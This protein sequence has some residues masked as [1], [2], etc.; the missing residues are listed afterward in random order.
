MAGAWSD[1][2]LAEGGRSEYVI[3]LPGEASPSE[4]HAANELQSF[5]QQICGAKLPIVNDDEPPAAAE[6][7]LAP[8]PKRLWRAG[9][10]NKRLGQLGVRVDWE[11]L[12]D[13]GFTIRTIGNHL[14]IAGGRLRGTLYGVYT[15]LEEHVGCRWFAEDCSQVPKRETI[16]LDHIDDTQIPLLEYRDTDYPCS[17][18]ADFA[19][20]N[21]LNGTHPRL[22]EARGGKISYSHF[23]HTFNSL[24][25]PDEYFEAHPE[26]FSLINGR[27]TKERT[28]LC[29]TNPDVLRIATQTVK[30][31]IKAAPDARIF[32]VSQNDWRNWCQCDR[33]TAVAEREGSQSGP[34]LQFV[35]AIAEQIEKEHP[36]VAISTLAYQYTRQPPKHVKPRD[37]VIVRL[38]SIEC[39]F[40]HPLA[41][42]ERNASFADDIRRW[43]RICDRLYIW[44]YVIDYSH[45]IMPFPNL[46]V[47]QPNIK[48]F[49][50][51]GVKGI[52][53]ESN[54]FSRGGEFSK[55]RTYL[56]AKALWNPDCDL[57]KHMDE[58]LEGYYG[59]A[60]RPI[61]QYIDM[62]HDKVQE[63]NIHCTI[64]T[65]PTSPLFSP[66]IVAR[67][68]RLFD[69]AEK[70]VADDATLLHRVQVALLPI[71]YVEISQG[72]P[73]YRLRGD[74]FVSEMGPERQALIDTF[75]RVAKAAKVT[76]IREGS[77]GLIEDWL[78]RLPQPRRGHP[79]LELVSPTLRVQIIPSLG[80]RIYSILDRRLYTNVLHVADRN[81]PLYPG[82]GGY[83]EYSES[84]Y[85]SPGWSEEYRVEETTSGS[86]VLVARLKNGLEL[87]RSIVL[88]ADEPKL[89]ITSTLTNRAKDP[90]TACLRVHPEFS[91]GRVDDAVL[92]MRRESGTW[93]SL[94]LAGALSDDPPQGK[95]LY[96]RG[97]EMPAGEW[98][99]VDTAKKLGVISAFEPR[100]VELCLLNF[101]GAEHRVNLELWSPERQ[102]AP[103]ESIIVT[104]TYRVVENT[105]P[106]LGDLR[107]APAG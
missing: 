97:D 98:M 30:E 65:P 50:E 63:E 51:N 34:L 73:K 22:D 11:K 40:A 26:Y 70:T 60:A 46:R 14:V 28:Q 47:L 64:R 18:D 7:I 94:D 13:E 12:G 103:G 5:L 36:R 90:R 92:Y 16:H 107:L 86:A 69:E 68:K 35:N 72:S 85:R 76:H 52:Y 17:R 31:W 66:D 4:E 89:S 21:K 32:S 25:P 3:V 29:L 80:G 37:N 55:L 2:V 102:L 38:C 106:L 87:R 79:V 75:A 41:T 45:C 101:S 82:V 43:N 48:F 8:S 71:Q 74:A 61:R 105:V 100:E 91:L 95:E 10:R 42:C 49:V 59:A 24:V 93:S 20:R 78:G 19:V 67:A 15:F 39:C 58:F 84:G 33:C 57:E 56:M 23:V 83:E 9:G 96:F 77:R 54:Y 44:D 62:I 53:E 88:A 81:D 1:I 104:Q 99:L 6:I 27:R